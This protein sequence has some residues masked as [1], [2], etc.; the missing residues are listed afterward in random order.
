VAEFLV[1]VGRECEVTRVPVEKS[2]SL[3]VTAPR[4]TTQ[5]RELAEAIYSFPDVAARLRTIR[6]LVE[7]YRSVLIFTNTRTEAEALSSRF[8]VWD[9]EF[10]IGIHHRSLSKSTR[11]A[12]ESCLKDGR[13]QGVIC[14]SSLEL[15]IDIGFLEYVVQYNSPRQ[16]TRLIQRV[17]RSGHRVGQVSSGVVITQDSDD[18]L[19]A[20]V[21]C[22]RS[23]KGELEP[24]DL[25][26]APYDVA[27]HQ[28]AGLLV[29]RS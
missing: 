1:G 9:P 26:M 29:E 12:V 8:R 24:L 7:K 3:R 16:V 6:D 15:G 13:L 28:V 14:T 21:L 18:T 20:A 5:D 11:E 17:G 10:P 27:I 2:L 19:E 4:A 22:R 25:V 23:M